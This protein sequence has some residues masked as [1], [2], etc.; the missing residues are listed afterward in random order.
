ED[1][2][3][4]AAD[5]TDRAHLVLERVARVR[6][7]R[8]AR[9]Q[10]APLGIAFRVGGRGAALEAARA[11]R[12]ALEVPRVDFH[13]ADR[14]ARAE[15]NDRPVVARPAAAAR[16]PAVAHVR[17]VARHDQVVARAEE[18]V[19]A[20]DDHTAVLDGGQIDVALTPQSLPVRHHFAV[21][22][23]PSHA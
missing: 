8:R 4:H 19:A 7:E 22:T 21:D 5:R 15:A 2:E 23:Q 11:G 9:H 12:V 17:G 16:L 18:A 20:V 13:A 1:V 3:A 10:L 6:R 14:A